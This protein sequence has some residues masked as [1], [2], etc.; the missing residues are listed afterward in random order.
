MPEELQDIDHLIASLATA[1]SKASAAVLAPYGLSPLE[2]GILDWCRRGEAN[3]VS[4]LAAAFPF[5][6]SVISRQ[7][8]RLV[9]LG[10]LHKGRAA[11]DR[12]RVELTLTDEGLALAQRLEEPVRNS[13]ARITQGVGEE[14]WSAFAAT[15]YK[16][17]ANLEG[18]S[19]RPWAWNQED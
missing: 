19:R 7:A 9:S 8:S 17:L 1:A 14:E 11:D 15:A 18:M 6:T 3:S 2:F 13:R 12:R 5:D 16:I 10:L 4:D